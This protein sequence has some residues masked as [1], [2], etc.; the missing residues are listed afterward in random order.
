MFLTNYV[1]HFSKYGNPKISILWLFYLFMS[2]YR[3]KEEHLAQLPHLNFILLCCL[4]CLLQ[5]KTQNTNSVTFSGKWNFKWIICIFWYIILYKLVEP[6]SA[7]LNNLNLSLE[8]VFPM[9]LCDFFLTLALSSRQTQQI[10][11]SKVLILCGWPFLKLG[12]SNDICWV[13][14]QFCSL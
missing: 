12:Y 2:L 8:K 9:F 10:R 1:L 3:H 6:R 7:F 14:Y 13:L 11:C 4:M 5:I